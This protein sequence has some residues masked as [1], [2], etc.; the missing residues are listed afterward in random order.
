MPNR[1][2]SRRD[3]QKGKNGFSTSKGFTVIELMIAVGV[4][5][6][7]TSLALAG[8]IITQVYWMNRAYELKYEQFS[9]QANVSLKAVANKIFDLQLDSA[10]KYNLTPCDSALFKQVDITEI[11]NPTILDSLIYKEFSCMYIDNY[12]YGVY[13]TQTKKFLIAKHVLCAV[14][15][16][17]SV[18]S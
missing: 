10:A 1:A 12:I 9:T 13:N 3:P 11:I 6:I 4:L 16:S 8:I 15:V 7:I 14:T 2:H 5:A 18:R 17:T